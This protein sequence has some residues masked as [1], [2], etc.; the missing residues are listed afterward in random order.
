MAVLIAIYVLNPAAILLP[1]LAI[2]RSLLLLLLCGGIWRITLRRHSPYAMLLALCIAAVTVPLIYIGNSLWLNIGTQWY[3]Q[4]PLLIMLLVIPLAV[5][6]ALAHPRSDRYVPWGAALAALSVSLFGTWNLWSELSAPPYDFTVYWEA[7]QRLRQ[8]L[9]IYEINQLIEAPFSGVYKYH[10]IFLFSIL[11]FS[12][13]LLEIDSLLW[14][15][16]NLAAIVISG[17]IALRVYRGKP[18]IPGAILAVLL[19]NLSPITQSLRLGQIDGLLLLGL[20]LILVV[21][22]EEQPW[23]AGILWALMSIIKIYPVILVLPDLLKHRWRLMLIGGIS[24]A[25]IVILSGTLFGW[26][27]ERTFWQEVVPSLGARTTRLSNQS[28]YGMIGRTLYPAS[29]DSDSQAVALPLASALHGLLA[30]FVLGSTYWA[31]W[32]QQRHQHTREAHLSAISALIC[33]MLLV[34]P[35]SWD[36]YEALLALPLLGGCVIALRH[37]AQRPLLLGAYTLLA[38]GTSKQVQ[39]GLIDSEVVL[40][41]ASYRTVGMLLLWGWWL[42]WLLKEAADIEPT[43]S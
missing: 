4:R 13:Y 30:A 16:G 18:L 19:L 7:A 37:E 24:I 6:L 40:F 41:I 8:G 32:R 43:V 29:A 11:P 15:A 38:F 31:V 33:A 28:L 34:I 20:V 10:P 36:H 17:V 39:N 27:Q 2:I 26:F 12:T 14:R 21:S 1:S 9:P 22:Q 23:L 25:G 3:A 42:W 5:G 35:V